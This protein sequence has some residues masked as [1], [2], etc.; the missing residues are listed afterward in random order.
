MIFDFLESNCEGLGEA[1]FGEDYYPDYPY[2]N[3][4]ISE[5]ENDQVAYICQEAFEF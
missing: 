2:L 3:C 1:I 5:Y 4:L